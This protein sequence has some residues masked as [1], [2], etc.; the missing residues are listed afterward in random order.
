MSKEE[1]ERKRKAKQ[2]HDAIEREKLVKEQ[3]WMGR[4]GG[5]DNSISMT[6]SLETHPRR[7]HNGQKQKKAIDLAGGFPPA[8]PRSAGCS[9]SVSRS[10]S[11][12]GLSGPPTRSEENVTAETSTM[13]RNTKLQM[14]PFIQENSK[15]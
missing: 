6:N 12:P 3:G 15:K 5:M 1:R 9:L 10:N 14:S 13:K 11:A 8:R 7:S 2:L 4:S